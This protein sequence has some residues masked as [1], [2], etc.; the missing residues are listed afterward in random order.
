[1]LRPRQQLTDFFV[2]G[3]REVLVP[4]ADGEKRLGCYGADDVIGFRFQ[5]PAGLW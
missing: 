3:L 1:M 2:R 4:V 5:L